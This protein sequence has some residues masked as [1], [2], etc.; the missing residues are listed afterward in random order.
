MVGSDSAARSDTVQWKTGIAGLQKD[1]IALDDFASMTSASDLIRRHDTDAKT[2]LAGALLSTELSKL[3]LSM[4]YLASNNLITSREASSAFEL[5]QRAN[6]LDLL[7]AL[8]STNLPAIK[9]ISRTFLPAVVKSGDTKMVKT[10]LSTGI[11]IN[12]PLDYWSET[13]LL[14]AVRQ[15]NLQMTEFLLEHGA[16]AR[17]PP[18]IL[19]AAVT[20]G[21]LQLMKL[22]HDSG[23]RDETRTTWRWDMTALQSAASN[24]HVEIV[25]YLL[26]CGVSD[27]ADAGREGETVV[28][29]AASTGI[30]DLVALVL[31]Y[32]PNDI[33]TAI[34]TSINAGHDKVAMD[35]IYQGKDLDMP[36]RETPLQAASRKGNGELVRTLVGMSA[37]VNAAPIGG[38]AMT[39]LQGAASHGNL[40]LVQF[41]VENGAETNDTPADFEGMTALQAAA[42]AG[43]LRVVQYLLQHGADINSDAAEMGGQSALLAAVHSG[44]MELIQFLINK[45]ADVNDESGCFHHTA[46]EAAVEYGN[47]QLVRLLLDHGADPNA[48]DA[49]PLII[50]ASDKSYEIV[51]L[52]L[53]RGADVNK[54]NFYGKTAIERMVEDGSCDFDIIKLLLQHKARKTDALPAVAESGDIELAKFFLD[55]EV[56]INATRRSGPSALARA[57]RAGDLDMVRLFLGY[58][59]NDRSAALLAAVEVSHLTLVR[60]LVRAGACVNTRQGADSYLCGAPVLAV[61]AFH[62]NLEIVRLLLDSGADVEVTEDTDDSTTRMLKRTTALQYAAIKGHLSVVHELVSRG[63]DVN[64]PAWSDDQRTALEGAA[65]HGRLDTVQFLI[66]VQANVHTSRALQFARKEGHDAVVALLMMQ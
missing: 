39:A 27:D 63:A 44:D 66:N 30:W 57:A 25:R 49:E 60:L 58:G 12:S 24:G 52:L 53:D 26:S 4:V 42:S 51:K 8:A 23:A 64:A 35:V 16:D 3:L 10:L 31:E 6:C 47:L 59:A 22:L 40:E 21:N 45:G 28:Q 18:E 61:A 38:H 37:N 2:S 32:H 54:A 41:L 14:I 9:A 20:T 1:D 15:G 7:V 13:L 48:P 19:Y 36:N 34:V 65:E 5:L 62:G 33:Y 55:S 50:A 11:D 46:L 56:D 17:R 29:A 43:N